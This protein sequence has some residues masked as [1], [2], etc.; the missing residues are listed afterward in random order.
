MKYVREVTDMIIRNIKYALFLTTILFLFSPIVCFAAGDEYSDDELY[1]MAY[2]YFRDNDSVQYHEAQGEIT[3]SISQDANGM[4]EIHLYIDRGLYYETM[5]VY[6]VDRMTGI[7]V[8]EENNAVDLRKAILYR[9][10]QTYSDIFFA[11]NTSL[12]KMGENV[13]DDEG[14]EMV[15][16]G[17]YDI[18]T[19]SGISDYLMGIFSPRITQNLLD[20]Y[21]NVDNKL[22]RA[23]ADRG[24]DMTILDWKCMEIREDSTRRV[25][26]VRLSIDDDLDGMED[27]YK[28]LRFE[29]TNIK[30]EW[31]FDVFPYFY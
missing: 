29:Q 15:Q 25:Y 23:N 28:M 7:G 27:S 6:I 9:A 12:W 18:D 3:M 30:G 26:E 31:I 13:F 2:H 20:N 14:Y 21:K 10:M 17:F 16:V 11:T 5:A 19:Y 22:F 24:S 4:T 1:N 8:D